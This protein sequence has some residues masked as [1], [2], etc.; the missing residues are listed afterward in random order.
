M[1]ISANHTAD[2]RARG[3]V[4]VVDD[5]A[6]LLDAHLSALREAGFTAAGVPD[7][8]A[9][10]AALTGE[11]PE[12]IL[13][14]IHLPD[15]DGRDLCQ[16]LK[17]EPTTAHVTVVYISGDEPHGELQGGAD[18]YI[19]RP[20]SDHELVARVDA[21]LRVKRTETELRTVTTE[22][23]NASRTVRQMMEYS[24]D[25]IC[26]M[27]KAGKFVEISAAGERVFGFRRE[28]MVGRRLLDLVHPGDHVRTRAELTSIM[29][30]KETRD[31]ENRCQCKDGRLAHVS[32][33]AY[34]ADAEQTMFCVARDVTERKRAEAFI[35][36]QRQV[37]E[38]IAR[39]APLSEALGNI[40]HLVEAQEPGLSCCIMLLDEAGSSLHTAAAPSLPA[41]F[42][43]RIDGL[44]VG[45]DAGSCGTAVCRRELVVAEDIAVDPLWKEFRPLALA[46]G[47]RACWSVP[48]M[49]NEGR[50]L[51]T[52][53]SYLFTPGRPTAQHLESI[54]TA[55]QLAS[56]AI[57]RNRA[58]R[59]LERSQQR[60]RS[61]FDQHPDAV[62]SIDLQGRLVSVNAAAERLS[63][64]SAAELHLTPAE[65]FVMPEHRAQAAQ[66]FARSVAGEAVTNELHHLRRDGKRRIALVTSLPIVVDGEITGTFAIS[67]DVT[68]R[69]EAQ[70]AAKALAERLHNTLESMTD[71]FYTLDREWRFTYLNSEAERLLQ[72]PRSELMQ[73]SVWEELSQLVKSALHDE[74]HACLAE[75]RPAHFE[76]Y[77]P[78]CEQWLDV[79][80][81]PN[82]DGLAVYFRDITDRKKTE[83]IL[84]ESR[85][86]FL[87]VIR[88]TNHA[89]WD[90]DLATDE[91]RWGE[92][93]ENVFGHPASE[94]DPGARFWYD[95]I[96]PEDRERVFAGLREFIRSGKGVWTDEYRFRCADGRYAFVH[97]RGFVILDAKDHPARMVGGMIDLSERHKQVEQLRE[98]EERFRQFAENVEDVFWIR[99]LESDRI[100]YVNPAFDIVMGFARELI[101][102]NSLLPV[103]AIHPEDQ[104]AMRKARAERPHAYN[105]EFRIVRPSGAVRWL[106][107]R[108]VPIYDAEGRIYRVAGIA[109]DITE[110]KEAEEVI[111]EQAALLDHA[112]EA[113]FVQ[114]L[115]GKV[116]YW[117][118]SAGRTYAC[119]ASDIVGR[120]FVPSAESNSEQHAAAWR[121]VLEKGDWI[122]EL[123]EKTN[124]GR[125]LTIE[126]HWTLVRNAAGAPKSILCINTD[127]TERKR[128]E[129]QFLRAQRMESIGTLAGGIAHDL[130]NVLSPIMMATELLKLKCEDPVNLSVLETVEMSARRGAD[131]VKQVLSFARGVEGRR[132][133]VQPR[134]LI[135]DI[136]K[137]LADTFPKNL[138]LRFRTAPDLWNVVGDPTQFHQVLL[139][140]CVNARD[141]MQDNGR[142][143][144][145]AENFAVDESYAAM[146]IEASVGPYVVIRVQ[147]TG[148]GMSPEVIERIYDPFYTTKELG[149]GTGLGLS[150]TLAIVRSHR[151]FI[152]VDSEVGK[153][154]TFAIHL[155]ASPE[156]EAPST[157]AGEA[158]LPRGNGELVLV[159]DDEAR[160]R[161]IT[162]QTLEAFGYRVLLASDGADAVAIYAR[163]QK[164][165]AVVLTDMM[166]P[167]MDGPSTIQVLIKMN[168]EAKI[169]AAS[170][171]SA[172][173]PLAK[174]TCANV[175]HF[176]P[177]PYTAETML[178]ALSC[179]LTSIPA[180]TASR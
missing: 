150:T 145:S 158:D 153:G 80:A 65:N 100:V 50:V 43:R 67:H 3:R 23:Q 122:G 58:A 129:T 8:E 177:K 178:R 17:S 94:I 148:S 155:P 68:E 149:K 38:L 84:T 60:Y 33:S 16:R 86:R 113:I 173:G 2:H 36:G 41:T 25:V 30:G 97:D 32:W 85:E 161:T 62:F 111:H 45:P 139:N 156:S 4:L 40:A 132:L 57:E 105:D 27:N 31:F 44:R 170:G 46:H 91:I 125:E 167:V 120:R 72:R 112:Q 108:T 34:W 131:M 73:R 96:H 87:Q 64:F 15:C 134:H 143:S 48:I 138:E 35:A 37:L 142:L 66:Q 75:N 141:A 56:I 92:G 137:I 24:L 74:F 20:V 22:L 101:Y 169:I 99:E 21:S 147:D 180:D 166:M 164:E 89:V 55:A 126:G 49:S 127:I 117:N 172:N 28:E 175:K 95:H 13:L 82:P 162:K 152:R 154:T 176:L 103:D 106:W 47:V 124:D 128:L 133:L 54:A 77:S 110:R 79:H 9:C 121:Q 12:L 146:N 88:T 78:T 98:T 130:N 63:G 140:L 26:T 51:G 102:E 168:P 61:L 59:E 18:G 174:A 109:R 70:H 71:A 123:T 5:D 104:A 179:V 6:D 160:I 136:K 151:G 29:A 135:N 163:E 90:W 171:M 107:A 83:Q 39:S 7:A 14:D 10:F 165:I 76:F 93:F 52:F 119:K 157:D 144:V 69:R 114:D 42:S 159:V 116:L 1:P 11:L 19:G 53:A 118:Q 115:N 81:Y